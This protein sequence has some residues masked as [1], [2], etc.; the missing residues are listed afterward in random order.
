MRTNIPS[1]RLPAEV[2][3]E[4]VDLIL[5]MGIETKFDTEVTSMKALLDEKFDAIFV[6]TGAPRGKEINI[7]GRQEANKNIHIG[8]DWLTSIAFEH[9]NSIGK[10]VVVLGG[11]NT[12]MDCCRSSLRL[13]AEDV[14]VVVRSPFDQMK[15][16]EW[17]LEEAMDENIPIFDNHVPVSYTHLTLT[18]KA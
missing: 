11:G 16:S 6:G 17:E 18:T 1:F 4:E 3:D 9:T 5:N 13:G 7:E 10:K 8:I 2:L 14:K 12:A 15:A